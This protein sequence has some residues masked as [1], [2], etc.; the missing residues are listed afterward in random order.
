M[1]NILQV[2]ASDWGGGAANIAWN[3]FQAY[4]AR[5]HNASLAV[6]AKRSSDPDVFLIAN[7]AHRPR[8][9]RW[10]KHA[11][12]SVAREANDFGGAGWIREA[13]SFVA[14]PRN[15]LE[16]WRGHENYDFPGSWH[17]LDLPAD[18]PDVLH[19]H[20]LHAEYFDLRAL[21]GL[22]HQIPTIVTLHDAWL[23]SGH[24]AHTMGCEKWRMGCGDCPDLTIYPAISRD[25]TNYNWIR[26]QEIYAK[27][28]LYV[29]TPCMWL[30]RQVEDSMLAPAIM[31]KRVIPNGVPLSVFYPGD[32]ERVRARLGIPQD[33]RVLLFTA[34][35]VRGNR[36]K[37]Y[38]T[39]RTAVALASAHLEG[40]AVLFLALGEEGLPERVGRAEI[41]FMPYQSDADAVADY[42]RAADLYLHAAHADT[43]PNAILE[44]LACG[45]PVIATAIAG[46]PEQVK[47]LRRPGAVSD[48]NGFSD[49]EATGLLIGTGDA[50]AMS[51]GI[52]RLLQDSSLRECLG[53]NAA[54]DARDRFGLER[55]VDDYLRWY[56]ALSHQGSEPRH[57]THAR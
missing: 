39:M 55:V 3:L 50:T 47:G 12:E 52:I 42:Y 40:E 34:D 21:A 48:T 45:T 22:S 38:Q 31:E 43:F 33:S 14:R 2:S 24:C 27:S 18:R 4:R 13:F 41:R 53:R 25:A 8:W 11:G 10:C 49:S 51:A 17:V 32:R 1:A 36:F 5:E 56:C 9:S 30:M 7:D 35:G 46:I 16:I 37:D 20:N 44:A 28:R 57:E 19:C 29:S 23:L 54:R 6:G 26:K 15:Q